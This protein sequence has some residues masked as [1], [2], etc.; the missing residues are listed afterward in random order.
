MGNERRLVDDV[1][2]VTKRA[3]DPALDN[4]KVGRRSLAPHEIVILDQVLS[5]LVLRVY[6]RLQFQYEGEPASD[7]KAKKI[8]LEKAEI[9]NRM[10]DDLL[11]AVKIFGLKRPAVLSDEDIS[12]VTVV[13]LGE[14]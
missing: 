13:I 5:A 9:L 8:A 3:T 4:I 11:R 12:V 14:M 10:Q 6:R 2:V 7:E 1:A